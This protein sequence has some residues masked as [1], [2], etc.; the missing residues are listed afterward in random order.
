[1]EDPHPHI[2]MPFFD[3]QMIKHCT[4]SLMLEMT[5]DRV[6]LRY[7]IRKN[8]FKVQGKGDTFTLDVWY[9]KQYRYTECEQHMGK[10]DRR[11]ICKRCHG[12]FTEHG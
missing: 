9:E 8:S 11:G 3:E 10:P 7:E 12:W 5:K 4:H 6:N 1:M 2:H